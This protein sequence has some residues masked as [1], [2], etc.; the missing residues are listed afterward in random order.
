M[1]EPEVEFVHTSS[2]QDSGHT[3]GV[4]AEGT[5]YSRCHNAKICNNE[6]GEL[7]RFGNS[8][9]FLPI[10]FDD[11]RVAC[12]YTGGFPSSGHSALLDTSGNL[13][14][15]GCDRW[16]QLGLGSSHGGSSGYTWKGGRLWQDHFQRCDH[17]V[18]LLRSLDPS[19]GSN[20]VMK[21]QIPLSSSRR[22]IRDVALGGDHTV[23]LSSNRKDVIVFG[24]GGENQLGLSSKPWVSSPAKSKVLSSS[25]ANISAVC[26]FRNCSITL[27]TKGEV[28]NKTGK[29][30]KQLKGIERAFDMCRKR[31]Q[32]SGLIS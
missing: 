12:A 20:V 26:A 13:W 10:E 31:A 21:Q 9:T 4:T 22:W 11:I 2:A 1:P 27:D 3:I 28:L 15:C 17:V 19:L 16:Q 32:E 14:M 23:I 30:S 5:A 24:K 25:T 8:S 18:E 6:L 29:C 7:G